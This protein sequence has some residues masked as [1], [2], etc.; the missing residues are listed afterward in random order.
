[1]D[2]KT[3]VRK[4]LILAKLCEGYLLAAQSS[5][6]KV[7]H[8]Q[9]DDLE[10]FEHTNCKPISVVLAVEFK[11]RLL[12][13][14]RCAEMPAKGLLAQI[15][16]KK[17]GI[18]RDQRKSKRRELFSSLKPFLIDNPRI[19]SDQNPH[20]RADVLE[21][22]PQA[23]YRTFKGRKACVAGQG[24]LKKGGFDPLFSLNHTCAMLRANVNRLIRKTWCTTKKM[25]R[26]Q[27]HLSLMAVFHNEMIK[28]KQPKRANPDN[29]FFAL[30]VPKIL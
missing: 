17:Y 2:R 27:M 24:E 18:R 19:D 11:S 1:V 16:R 12:L 4:F 7:S 3:V 30:A 23:T 15:S 26:L 5:R 14:F 21:F 25:Q 20:Y 8:M 28:R 29:S 13:G 6:P 22:F 10:T 9:F